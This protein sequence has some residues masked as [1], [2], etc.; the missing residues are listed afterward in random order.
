[1]KL[2]LIAVGI[3][4]ALS[5][6]AAAQDTG[7]ITGTVR[8]KSG[9]VIV[10]ATVT[11]SSAAANI[12]R[13]LST[14]AD[15][16]FLAASLPGGTYKL[17]V[18]AP[19]FRKFSANN[20]ALRVTQ[21]AR[22]DVTMEVGDTQ[23]I[24]VVE[25]Q[26]L[27]TVET[28]S[29]EV[30]GTITGKEITQLQLNGRDFTQLVTLVPGVSNQ[31]GQD[32][33]TVGVF[34][35]VQYSFN[36]GRTEYNNWELD[37]GDNMD[38]GSNSTLNVTPSI[39]AIAEFRVLTSNYGAQYGRNGSGTVEVETKSGT[40]GFHGELFEFLRNDAFNARNFFDATVPSYKK[41]DF[42]Y[43]L[44]GPVFIPH[45]FN[46]NREKTF[47]FWSENWRIDR[48]PP[49]SPFNTPVPSA[50]ERQGNFNDL[51][52]NPTTGSNQDCPI[53][54]ATGQPFPNN[55]LPVNPNGQALL[56]LIPLPTINTPGATIFQANPILPTNWREE[57]VRVDHNFNS[58]LTGTVRFIHDSWDTITPS[59]LWTNGGSFPT[60][61]TNFRGPG[62]SLVTKLTAIASPTLLNE[63]VF[64]Y[65]ADHIFLNDTGAFQRPAGFTAPGL[66]NN[67]F[68]GKLPGFSLS[69]GI[70]NGLAEDAGF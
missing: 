70:Y 17:A 49:N 57:L 54:P 42:G 43:T 4:A 51:C 10:N 53:N 56:G 37:G 25:G 31:T 27:N 34:G 45:L 5:S 41:N 38:N 39:E 48:V 23:N 2:K 14:N 21:K 9:A 7:S 65:T 28:Q 24:V 32:E 13:T 3:L 44:G 50:A 68:G 1:M 16:D 33:G 69:G 46:T 61:Q 11:I 36:G 29:S 63:F 40:R 22:V 47:F 19:G 66:F 15:G 52:P 18:A 12:T 64:S 55:Q 35:N 62:V 59:P 26:G 60:V 30:A 58:R 20:I 6:L 8:D 67:G